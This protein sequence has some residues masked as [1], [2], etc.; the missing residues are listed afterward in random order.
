M[1]EIPKRPVDQPP[2]P[3]VKGRLTFAIVTGLCTLIV[4]GYAA[5]AFTQKELGKENRDE[6]PSSMRSTPGGY[7]SYSYWH[8]GYRGGK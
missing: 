4:G 3:R 5:F 6:I 7:R 8:S 2:V 1:T